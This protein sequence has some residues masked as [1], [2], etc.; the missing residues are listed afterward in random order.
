MR[1]P[2]AAALAGF[3][4]ALPASGHFAE[5]QIYVLDRRNELVYFLVNTDRDQWKGQLMLSSA[6]GLEDPSGLGFNSHGEMMIAN[7]PTDT[8]LQFFADFH[9]DQVLDARDQVAGPGGPGAFTVDRYGWVYL[10]CESAGKILRISQDFQWSYVFADA[11]D[12]LVQPSGLTFTG[13]GRMLVANAGSGGQVLLIDSLGNATVFDTIA[14]ENPRS[15]LWRDNQDVYVACDSGNLYRYLGGQ[16]GNR[17]LLGQ[18]GGHSP[19]IATDT[20]HTRLYHVNRGDGEVRTIDLDTGFSKSRIQLGWDAA[21]IAVVAGQN[22]PGALMEVSPGLAGSAARIPEVH[23]Q[24]DPR[25]GGQVHLSPEHFLGGTTAWLCIGVARHSIPQF[26]GEFI[27]DLG[28]WH[29]FEVLH[30]WGLDGVPGAGFLHKAYAIPND[31]ALS[32]AR[33]YLQVLALDPS[34]VEGVSI[35]PGNRLWLGQ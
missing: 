5:N 14:G 1:R 13:D 26:G 25:P 18:Y 24:G 22:P 3:C 9:G 11:A 35:T 34:A 12:G 28:Q 23:V 6:A 19:S 29:A 20:G 30:L 17:I 8:V 4:L 7:F 31:S 21:A 2:L 33:L 10:A 32:M 16:A 27:V 15:V